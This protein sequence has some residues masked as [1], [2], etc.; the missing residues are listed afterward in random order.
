MKPILYGPGETSFTNNG[1][2]RLADC[3]SC[4]VTEERNGIYECQFTYPVTGEMYSKI[5]IGCIL[6]VIHDDA[7]DVQPFDI[8]AKDAPMNGVVTF[9][10]HHISYRLGH[11][12]L[13][14]VSYSSI[15]AAF[16]GI[17]SKTYNSCPFTFWT[18]KSVSATWNV[19]VPSA[20]KAV[21]GGVH[22]SILDVY[23]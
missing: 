23:G 12:I 22:G 5:Q 6:G 17:P 18:D 10:G 15:T 13:K 2:G 21:L 3:I 16:A 11:V 20:V 14:P 1:L 19:E 7:K 8:Y 9:Y 4:K